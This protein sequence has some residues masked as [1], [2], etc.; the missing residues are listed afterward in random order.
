MIYIGDE[1]ID[2]VHGLVTVS[3]V[4]G[5]YNVYLTC[6]DGTTIVRSI[7]WVE[8]FE[9]PNRRLDDIATD[10]RNEFIVYVVFAAIVSLVLWWVK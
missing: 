9:K 8:C 4:D 6:A 3:D 5:E 1:L 10:R 7:H 2:P